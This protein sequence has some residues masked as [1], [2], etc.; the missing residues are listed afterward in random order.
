MKRPTFTINQNNFGYEISLLDPN[1]EI[2]LTSKKHPN[3]KSCEKFLATLKVHMCFHSN[4]CRTKNMVGKYGFE[5]RTCWDELIA[6][7]RMFNS[8]EEREDGMQDVFKANKDAIFTHTSIQAP[9]KT[10][11]QICA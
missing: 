7:S 3:Y 4:F 5:V 10:T 9:E 2:M 11:L 8:R 1:K 6:T